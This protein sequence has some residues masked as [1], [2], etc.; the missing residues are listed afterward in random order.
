MSPVVL[1]AG[2]SVAVALVGLVVVGPDDR[3]AVL[4]GMAGPLLAACG[5]W[6]AAERTYRLR[7][8]ALTA[9]MVGGFAAKAVFFGVYVAVVVRVLAPQYGVFVAS[10]TG[11]LVGLYL[12]E[13]L[14]LRH[15]FR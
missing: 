15:L 1:M 8:E 3:P 13:A 9:V 5:S 11:Y 14:Y 2:S 10:F 4:L 12:V 6:V 7:P